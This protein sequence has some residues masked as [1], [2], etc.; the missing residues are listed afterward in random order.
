MGN[1]L[2]I[3]SIVPPGFYFTFKYKP[4]SAA[5]NLPDIWANF[6]QLY[7]IAYIQKDNYIATSDSVRLLQIVQKLPRMNWR[8]VDFY[9]YTDSVIELQLKEYSLIV[10]PQS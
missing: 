9:I 2:N 10:Y 3:D 8:G 4:W 6:A 7:N 1:V 5:G